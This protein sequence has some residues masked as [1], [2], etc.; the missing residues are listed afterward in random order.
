MAARS[1]RRPARVPVPTERREWTIASDVQAIMP[2]VD[3]IQALC[4]TAGFSPRHCRLNIPVAVTEALS[5]AMLRG[6]ACD[7]SRW[8]HVTVL[9]DVARLIVEV[10]DEGAGFDIAA[11]QRTPDE[12]DWLDR[13]DGRGLFLMRSLMDQVESRMPD[14]QRGHMVRL[15]LHRT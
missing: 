8:V 14:A 7:A 4:V 11:A 3:T 12:V 2:I 13:E 6:N 15:T 1:P 5:N 9:L 10:T